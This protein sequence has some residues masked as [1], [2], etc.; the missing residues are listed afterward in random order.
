[1]SAQCLLNGK[2]VAPD[3]FADRACQYGDGLFETL[4]VLDSVAC[5][6]H[7][8]LA[9]LFRGCDRLQL[10]LPDEV[11]LLEEIEQITSGC[12]KGVLKIILSAGESGRGYARPSPCRPTRILKLTGWP[13]SSLYNSARDLEVMRCK[14]PLGSQPLLAGI[15]HLNRLEQVLA[16]NELTEAFDEGLM[17]DAE[18]RPVSGIM[19][20]LYLHSD[21]H[22]LIPAIDQAGI[23]GIVREIFL[24][25]A[26]EQGVS[27][28]VR[29]VS[30]SELLAADSLYM[31]NSLLGMRQ[32]QRLDD[33]RFAAQSLALV[34]KINQ[35][36]W[37]TGER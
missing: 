24:E 4:T 2:A 28:E 14:T 3:C 5:Q 27:Y 35:L 9:R 11:R 31:S 22:W 30:D 8:H 33:H 7:R 1:M 13:Q 25:Q 20:N 23:A 12:E 34:A 21:Q 26:A 15:K 19:S 29:P 16:R 17:F 6:L 36:C 10:P 32:I 37:Q 18:G